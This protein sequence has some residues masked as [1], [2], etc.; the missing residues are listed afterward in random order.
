[1]TSLLE[2]TNCIYHLAIASLAITLE[3]SQAVS[4]AYPI[5]NSYNQLYIPNLKGINYMA[6]IEPLN[7]ITWMFIGFSCIVTPPF[8]YITTQ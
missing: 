1:M 8:L 5:Y 2:I 3:R 7:P 6:L 4:Y